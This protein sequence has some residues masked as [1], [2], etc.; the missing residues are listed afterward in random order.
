[1][2]DKTITLSNGIEIP[3]LAL[4]TWLIDDDEV[5]DVIKNAV[6]VGYR[7][8]DTAQAYANER[9][10]GEGVRNASVPREEIFVTSKV[11][12]ENKSYDSAYKSIDETLDKM[13]LIILI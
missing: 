5:A 1:M 10:V 7:H 4:G 12:A 13:G 11:M 3:Q 8:F 2:F 9:G 6:D